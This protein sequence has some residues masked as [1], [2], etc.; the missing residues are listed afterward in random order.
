MTAADRQRRYRQRRQ[1][2]ERIVQVPVGIEG[3]EALKAAGF[4]NRRDEDDTCA[5]QNAV[6]ELFELWTRK[7]TNKF[8]KTGGRDGQEAKDQTH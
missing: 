7:I 6:A 5:I 4:L 8:W 3:I 1:S 2:G